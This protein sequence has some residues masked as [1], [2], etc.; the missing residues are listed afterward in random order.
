[1]TTMLRW[2]ENEIRHV[3]KTNQVDDHVEFEE[4]HSE[5]IRPES[6]ERAELWSFRLKWLLTVSWS[7]WEEN[8]RPW[9]WRASICYV[10]QRCVL[11]KWQVCRSAL[12]CQ[13]TEAKFPPTPCCNIQKYV[14]VMKTFLT[15]SKA[16]SSFELSSSA[17]ADPAPWQ[18]FSC[19][20]IL[21]RTLK[22]F[23]QPSCLHLKGFSPVCEYVWIFKELGR[24]KA[25]EH[26]GHWYR[27][28]V[29]GNVS[30]GEPE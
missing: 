21:L 19:R 26:V 2:A 10:E 14:Q 8:V 20:F 24:E 1:M 6:L 27:S 4:Q 12:M 25:F 22:N 15:N 3:I 13:Y 11:T 9:L 17:L 30:G 16:Y 5:K 7:A 18:P 28:T 23:P 29:C